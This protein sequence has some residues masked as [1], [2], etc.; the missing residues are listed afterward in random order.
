M[1]QQGAVK[2]ELIFLIPM[3]IIMMLAMMIPSAL[4]MILLFSVYYKKK[5]H[6]PLIF[7]IIFICG[8]IFIWSLFAVAAAF[9]QWYL[10]TASLLTAGYQFLNS[11]MSGILLIFA[12]LYQFTPVKKACLKTCQS[13]LNFIAEHGREGKLGAFVMGL[14]HGLHCLGCCWVLMLLLFVVG[15]MNLLWVAL[16][17][18]IVLAEKLIRWK[19]FSSILGWVFISSGLVLLLFQR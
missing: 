8:Y 13:P 16:L 4:P 11:S 9:V 6:H 15:V 12:G 10:H 3:W 18:I 7:T 2:D 1:P 5:H 14:H 19:H 17:A